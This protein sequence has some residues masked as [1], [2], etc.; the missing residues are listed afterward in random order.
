M[1][2]FNGVVLGVLATAGLLSGCASTPTGE[3]FSRIVEPREGRALLYLYRGFGGFSASLSLEAADK[4]K[5]TADLAGL[6][7]EPERF[8]DKEI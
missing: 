1:K 3:A 2:R 8:I 6:K 5:A 7:R 4:S